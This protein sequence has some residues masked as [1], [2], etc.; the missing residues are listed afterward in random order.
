[1][2]IPKYDAWGLFVNP[3]YKKRTLKMLAAYFGYDLDELEA[4]CGR[5]EHEAAEAG[6]GFVKGFDDF[7]CNAIEHDLSIEPKK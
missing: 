7:L 5:Y 3:E 2:F 6:Y 4:E 1:M